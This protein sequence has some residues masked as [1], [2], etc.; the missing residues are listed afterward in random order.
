MG[1]AEVETMIEDR[2]ERATNKSSVRRF[3]VRRKFLTPSCT[4]PH[5]STSPSLAV[6]GDLGFH[7]GR[8]TRRRRIITSD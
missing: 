6:D 4:V 5:L 7:A 2:W 8:K 1:G 3:S